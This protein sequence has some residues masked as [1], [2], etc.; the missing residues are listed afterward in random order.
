M[1]EKD[2]DRIADKILEKMRNDKEIKA[3]KQ[4]TPFQKTEK[5]LYELKFLKGAIE[6]KRERLSGLHNAPVLLSKKE[7]GV[8][9]QST[10]KYLA[11]VEK[12]ENMIENCE[13]EIKRL[14][15]VISMTER[16]LKNIED[17]RYYKIIELKYFEEMT[18][19]YVAEKFGVDERTIRRQKN[20]LIN[21][22]RALIFSDNVIQDIMNY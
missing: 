22:L 10:K 21:R 14:E 2:I 16:A 17:D 6:V 18:L 8:N 20:R 4:L 11:E 15:H 19:E 3:E 1:N 9:V 13:N 5:L 7:T 12:I